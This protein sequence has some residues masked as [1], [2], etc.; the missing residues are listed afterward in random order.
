MSEKTVILEAAGAVLLLLNI[1][2]FCL[3]AADKRRARKG[4]WRIPEKTLFLSAACF[5]GLGAVLGMILCR[6]KTN[7]W[8]FRLFFPLFLFVQ[9]G[10]LFWAAWRFLS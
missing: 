3:M 9:A 7:H 1:L 8:Y 10:V 6:H 5:G 4:A 2:S